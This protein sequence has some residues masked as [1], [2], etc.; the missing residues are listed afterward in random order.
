MGVR[1]K[2]CIICARSKENE[3]KKH[4]CFRNWNG[5]SAA[6]ETDIIVEGFRMAEK[7][8][9][10]RYKYFIADGDSSVYANLV[11]K[12]SY[13]TCI[14]KIECV[15]HAIKN[16]GKYLYNIKKDSNV[17]ISIRKL[18]TQTK[19]Q[20]LQKVAQSAIYNHCINKNR[21]EFI[22]DLKNGPLHVFNQHEKCKDY[23]CNKIGEHD[24]N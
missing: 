19:I 20:A 11:E 4:M 12:V 7:L 16:Y 22:E 23:Y 24:E 13:G 17:A 3:E 1:N 14:R 6:M 10:L 8:Y 15:N 5:S 2:F 9:N 18:L 21:Q